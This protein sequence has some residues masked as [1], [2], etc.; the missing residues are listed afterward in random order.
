MACQRPGMDPGGTPG[1]PA[2]LS[3]LRS[4]PDASSF[5]V[6]VLTAEKH[7]VV[8][9]PQASPDMVFQS[10]PTWLQME[11]VHIFIRPNLGNLVLLDADSYSGDMGT[12]TSL[13]PRCLTETSPGNYQ[14]WLTLPGHLTSKSALQVTKDLSQAL[15]A[16]GCPG[17]G[18]SR[19]ARATWW[20][21]CTLACKT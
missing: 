3:F 2:A 13:Q 11:N 9:R 7:A 19:Q 5:N 8:S 16:A 6:L 1:L 20:S 12:L 4:F 14:A 10:L 15:G 17:P 18:T 21:S